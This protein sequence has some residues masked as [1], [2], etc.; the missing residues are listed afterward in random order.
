MLKNKIIKTICLTFLLFTG[1]A[2]AEDGIE[3]NNLRDLFIN[4]KSIMYAINIR[5]FGAVDLNNDG[6]IDKYA[7]EKR[8]TFINAVNKLDE[9][10]SMGFNTI[11]L[12]P[13]T[14]TGKLKALGTAGSLYA[15]DSFNTVNPQFDE[16]DNDL[17][18][19]DEAKIFIEEAH[20]KGLKIIIDMPCAGS[21][22]FSLQNK[23]LFLRDQNGQTIVPSDWTDIRLFKIYNGKSLNKDVL[24]GYKSFIDMTQE[25]G[26]DGI[27]ADV[28]GIKP[29]EFWSELIKYARVKDSQFLF[30]AEASPSWTNPTKAQNFYTS[31]KDLLDAG[32]DGY[33][34]EYGLVKNINK[35]KD[36]NKILKKERKILKKFNYNKSTISSFVTHDEQ[37]PTL[38]GTKGRSEMYTWLSVT[39]PVNPY[40][41]DGIPTGDDFNHS[42]T[43]QKALYSETDDEYYFVHKGK[44]DIFNFSKA[45][46]GKYNDLYEDVKK[47]IHFK[48]WTD[49]IIKNPNF[50]ILKTSNPNTFAYTKNNKQDF[51]IVIGNLSNKETIKTKVKLKNIKNKATIILIKSDTEPDFKTKNLTTTLKPSEIQVYLISNKKR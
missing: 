32:F 40:F 15:M 6:I 9:I 26:A 51:I 11:Y 27:R 21:Y 45:P 16:P 22:D 42:Y 29:K 18:V 37:S 13:I 25:L 47:A 23:E 14:K 24:D 1:V 44:M 5:N 41:L 31:V 2:N 49:K 50:N 39:L 7:G 10:K 3:K 38:N 34:G 30:L 20:K 12:L 43:N 36:L 33:Y 19:F 8:G 48:N 35:A 17:N 4:N 28:A 46:G